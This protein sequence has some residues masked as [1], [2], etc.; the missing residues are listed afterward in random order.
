[1]S[2][3]IASFALSAGPYL[4]GV[5]KLAVIVGAMA[6]AATRMR[7]LL[8]PG[9]A[10]AP[11]RLAEIVLAATGLLWTAELVGTFGEFRDS[12]M[13]LASLAIGFGVGLWASSKASAR[14]V[15][16]SG[17]PP[18]P[19]ASSLAKFLAVAVVTA[20]TAAWMIPTLGSVAA[21]M[22]RADTLWYHMPLATRFVQT[23]HTGSIFFFDPV[24]FAS[25]YP[26]NS[27]LFHSVGILVF[28][29]DILSLVL[30]DGWLALALLSC[31]CIGRPYGMGPQALIGGSVALGAQML[32]EFQAG[33]GL[34]DITGVAFLLA[35]AAIL[36]NAHAANKG[37]GALGVSPGG[38]PQHGREDGAMHGRE[39]VLR[40]IYPALPATAVA[41]FAAGIAAGV[42]LSFLAPLA[43]LTVG[44]MAVSGR[45]MRRKAGLAFLVPMVAA[46]GYWYARNLVAIGNPIPYIHHL[47]PIALPA[48]IRDFSLR[49]GFSVFHY[50]NDTGVWSHWFAPG[51][52]DS[53]GL[54]WP[55][56]LLGVVGVT[57]AVLIR[58]GE[59]MIRALGVV[60]G[61]AAVAYVFT[62]LT[63][64]GIEGQPIGFIWN[65]RYLAPSIA[66]AFAILP[67]LP[68]LRATSRRRALTLLGV[69]VL[70]AVT[71]GSLVQWHQGHVKG[72]LGAAA[73]VL[74]VAG[75]VAFA[76]SRGVRWS[77][78]ALWRRAA[79][80]VA[81]LGIVLV[82]G[83]KVQRQYM[84]HR[85]E[86][87]GSVP[88][89]DEAFTWVRGV[90]DSRIALAGVRGIFTQYA[91]Y[92]PDLSNHVQWLGRETAHDG[93]A[94]I[95]TCEQWMQAVNAG[96]YKYVVATH[97]P[98]DPGTLTNTP[99]GRWTGADPNAQ[100]V[101]S[102]GP[103]HIF[104]IEGPLDTSSCAGQN[105]LNNHQLHGVPDPTNPQ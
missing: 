37:Q 75:A 63:A 38:H 35:A 7:R 43:A 71:I 65:L 56:T 81:V 105:P 55:V 67:C 87:A 17:S 72:A 39:S 52:H 77:G 83:F 22:D 42:K 31:Y 18:A 57:I 29:R 50:W 11:A 21:G 82:G 27:E 15:R 51:L 8:L 12:V 49:P 84:Q 19:P 9:W 89:L 88:D 98:F 91:F 93:Y 1:M 95:R 33:E 10:G 30:N 79:I 32:V 103:L 60:A 23:G 5:L 61:F 104:S 20:L 40:G 59:R 85:Y 46:G 80:V 24:F 54:L 74:L 45:G 53:L 44:V 101:L 3:P 78:M 13:V 102:Q 94:R 62:P 58:E 92:G 70:A 66:L 41:G 2:V 16:P 73:I 97:D 26:A 28:N 86:D 25:F 47:G 100:L 64:S 76:R 14:P 6:F 96:N 4:A 69:F 68:W 48:P 90:H 36:V 34:N 99:E